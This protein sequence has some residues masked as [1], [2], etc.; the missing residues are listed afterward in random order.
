MARPWL[1][2]Q[3]S[4]AQ[5]LDGLNNVTRR[6]GLTY[7]SDSPDHIF[8]D[9]FTDGVVFFLARPERFRS[10]IKLSRVDLRPEPQSW[11]NRSDDTTHALP[12]QLNS[13]TSASVSYKSGT[14]Q[15]GGYAV[16]LDLGLQPT[17]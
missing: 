11:R 12:V 1:G 7:G 2:A 6:R 13:I 10:V 4:Y 5:G 3:S 14:L 8:A 9:R 16:A 15:Y 17:Q